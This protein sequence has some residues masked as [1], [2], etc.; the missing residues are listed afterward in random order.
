MQNTPGHEVQILYSGLIQQTLGLTRER[1]Q[2]SNDAT[3]LDVLLL[4]GRRHVNLGDT[5]FM[6]DGKSLVPNLIVLTD[7]RD[8]RQVK[9]TSTPAGRQLEIILVPPSTGGG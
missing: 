6:Y 9:G 2:V 8:I 5:L 1:L 7:G 3:V 4:I